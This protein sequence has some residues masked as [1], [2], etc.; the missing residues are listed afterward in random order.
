LDEGQGRRIF[1]LSALQI[2]IGL[3]RFF[4]IALAVV[5]WILAQES[6]CCTGGNEEVKIQTLAFLQT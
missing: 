3:R 1:F 5:F 6:N 2:L 4:L